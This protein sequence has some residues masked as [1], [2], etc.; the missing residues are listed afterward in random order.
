[1]TKKR[2]IFVAGLVFVFGLIL[3]IFQQSTNPKGGNLTTPILPSVSP[4][5]PS[6][7]PSSENKTVFI[8]DWK[9][10]QITNPINNYPVYRYQSLLTVYDINII[11]NSLGFLDTQKKNLLGDLIWKTDDQQQIFL[12]STK[13]KT[14]NYQK[15]SISDNNLPYNE[16]TAKQ[17][18][19]D[20]LKTFF[21]SENFRVKSVSYLPKNLYA[22]PVSSDKAAVMKIEVDQYIKDFPLIPQ[23]LINSNIAT[24]FI[25][26]DMTYSSF[27]INDGISNPQE[28]ATK[29]NFDF[30]SLKNISSSLFIK[31]TPLRLDQENTIKQANQLTFFVEKVEPAYISI[32][33]TV[34]PVY[35]LTGKIGRDNKTPID[36]TVQYIVPMN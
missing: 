17:K 5:Y 31:I 15:I 20:T 14:I 2:I 9:K 1:M 7:S 29:Q 3:Y 10:T 13:E 6:I 30:N 36:S 16:E 22:P 18:V 12:F 4:N 32:K 19:L 24:F 26:R 28:T 27:V 23:S 8:L 33:N 25:N 35:L 34:S 21:P 11:A